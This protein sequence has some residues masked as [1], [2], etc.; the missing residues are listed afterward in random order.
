MSVSI[1]I[2]IYVLFD[3]FLPCC[4]EVSFLLLWGLLAGASLGSLL[5]R[6]ARKIEQPDQPRVLVC[7]APPDST[8]F[9]GERGHQDEGKKGF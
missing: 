9:K 2:G 5:H 3:A 1:S 7:V 8:V 6:I 4:Y